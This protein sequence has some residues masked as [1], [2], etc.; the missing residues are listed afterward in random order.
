M[1]T[2]V[3]L[4][5]SGAEIIVLVPGPRCAIGEVHSID[6]ALRLSDNNVRSPIIEVPS[7]IRN[8]RRICPGTVC[9]LCDGKMQARGMRSVEDCSEVTVPAIR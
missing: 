9:D 8:A 7:S 6:F 3:E 1:V 5:I 4:S 2:R